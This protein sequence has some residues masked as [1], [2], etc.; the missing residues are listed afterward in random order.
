MVYAFVNAFTLSY[1]FLDLKYTKPKAR[2][3]LSDKGFGDICLTPLIN[4][5]PLANIIIKIKKRR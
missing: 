4:G 3:A 2:K 5:T 1:K